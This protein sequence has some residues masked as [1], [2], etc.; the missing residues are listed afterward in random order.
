MLTNFLQKSQGGKIGITLS[1]KWMVPLSN[2]H[3]DVEAAARA[4]D[5]QFGWFMD[6]VT[7]GDY[8]SSMQH[9]VRDRLPK[10][11]PKESLILKGSYDFLGVNYYTAKYV[12]H[13]PYSPLGNYS[14]DGCYKILSKF[15]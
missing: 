4:N 9:L 2:E 6:P 5:F 10:F 11:S 8:P 3:T 12:T 13:A 14:T 7:F 15:K 1:I